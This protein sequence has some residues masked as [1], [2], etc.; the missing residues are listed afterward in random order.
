MTKGSFVRLMSNVVYDG[1]NKA[2]Y[3]G[4]YLFIGQAIHESNTPFSAAS[5]A[6]EYIS[7]KVTI[8]LN[9]NDVTITAPSG[10]LKFKIDPPSTAPNMPGG[11]F[12]S[13]ALF[14]WIRTKVDHQMHGMFVNPNPFSCTLVQTLCEVLSDSSTACETR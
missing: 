13:D 1:L 8:K 4:E 11:S 14:Y 6:P 9:C 3:E 12:E 10:S 7:F 2:D 5:K